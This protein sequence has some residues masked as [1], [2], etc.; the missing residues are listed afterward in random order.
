MNI[1]FNIMI[2]NLKVKA[3]KLMLKLNYLCMYI[4]DMNIYNM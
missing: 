4:S 3:L 2:I 1:L